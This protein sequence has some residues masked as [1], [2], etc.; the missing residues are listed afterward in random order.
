MQGGFKIPI[1]LAIE[2]EHTER[3]QLCINKYEALIWENY[4]EPFNRKF[5]DTTA[6]ILGGLQ[7]S[8]EESSLGLKLRIETRALGLLLI[9]L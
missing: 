4:K 7:L 9:L 6:A 2:I 3:C 5:E 1:D 8:D